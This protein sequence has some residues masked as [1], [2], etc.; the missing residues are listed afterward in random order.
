[1][2]RL[3]EVD[4]SGQTGFYK[5]CEMQNGMAIAMYLDLSIKYYWGL[6]RVPQQYHVGLA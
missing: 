2:L 6:L 4:L 5:V 1:M 3:K